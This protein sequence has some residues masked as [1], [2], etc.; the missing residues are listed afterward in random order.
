MAVTIP[1]AVICIVLAMLTLGNASRLVFWSKK[2]SETASRLDAAVREMHHQVKNNL[3]QINAVENSPSWSSTVIIITWDDYGGFYDHVAPSK[4]DAL[5]YGFRVPLLVISPYAHAGDNS[6]PHISHDSFEFS[7]VL[8]LAEEI[9]HLPSLHQRDASAGDLMQTLDFSRTWN[10]PL[11]LSQ[12]K[13][14]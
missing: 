7:S 5:G 6:N 2:E 3:Q 8:K 12:R 4:V 14:P 1:L 11:F 10:K 13:C 9:Y